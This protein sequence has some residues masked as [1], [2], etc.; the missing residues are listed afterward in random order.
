MVEHH[1][2]AER[3]RDLKGRGDAYPPSKTVTV[4]RLKWMG[5]IASFLPF[6]S[7]R[8]VSAPPWQGSPPRFVRCVPMH[9]RD[10]ES[11]ARFRG[12]NGTHAYNSTNMRAPNTRE[13]T[14]WR[15]S[16]G[17]MA[18]MVSGVG[19]QGARPAL[20]WSAAMSGFVLR[21]FVDLIDDGIEV[22]SE[23]VDA[24]N[25]TGKGKTVDKGTPGDSIDTKPMSN[26][27]KRKRYMTDEDVAVFNGMKEAVSDVAA[28]VRESIHAEAAPGIY[29]AVINCPGFSREALM[30]ALNHMM[31]HKATSL[32]FLDMTPDDRDLWLK[33]FLA[34]HYHN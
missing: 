34:K 30:Y 14:V 25:L 22:T 18:D 23:F 28:A 2:K 12:A 1:G 16:C 5:R 26:L 7:A 15:A 29:N 9:T 13:S 21:R 31:E 17:A 10:L 4:A 11:A 24:S 20:R 27:G 8:S 33:T 19:S 3:R 6:A 32:V